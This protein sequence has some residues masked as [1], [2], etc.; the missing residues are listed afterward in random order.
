[1]FAAN[2]EGVP[3][4]PPS[5]LA[6]DGACKDPVRPRSGG[7]SSGGAG[8]PSPADAVRSTLAQTGDIAVPTA[9][10]RLVYEADVALRVVGGSSEVE[11]LPLMPVLVLVS[12]KY[13]AASVGLRCPPSP[14]RAGV[15]GR[16]GV[17]VCVCVYVWGLCV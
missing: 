2:T 14:L 9:G 11:V 10:A 15:V 5:L 16:V 8:D 7:G 6:P 13:T 17:C 1:V 4:V 12:C 3:L